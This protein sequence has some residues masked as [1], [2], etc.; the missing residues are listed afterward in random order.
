MK[1]KHEIELIIP[2][3]GL[4]QYI[5]DLA[6]QHNVAYVRTYGD[7]LADVITKLSGDDVEADDI[8]LL[9]RALSRAGVIS[10]KDMVTLLVN[11]LR[12]LKNEA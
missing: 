9:V 3:S 4:R 12:E 1:M 7:E 8:Q 11:Y 5:L 2:T 10:G 6:K